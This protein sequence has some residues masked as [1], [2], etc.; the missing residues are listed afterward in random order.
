[1]CLQ[2]S[3]TNRGFAFLVPLVLV[4]VQDTPKMRSSIEEVHKRFED[5]GKK[6]RS[7]KLLV[8]D[9]G[10]ADGLSGIGSGG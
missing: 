2:L 1:M 7:L 10:V 9:E 6:L 5:I 3:E 8:R 4:M